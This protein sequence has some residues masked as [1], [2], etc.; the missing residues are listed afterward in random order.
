MVY[1]NP[2]FK[3][4]IDLSVVIP[5]FNEEG[6]ISH[7]LSELKRLFDKESIQNYELLIINDGSNDGTRAE[8]SSLKQKIPKLKVINLSRNVGHMLSLEIGMRHTIGEFIITMDGDF[9]DLPSDAIRMYVEAKRLT[10]EGRAFQV[11]QGVRTDRQTDSF[12]KRITAASYYKLMSLL[13]GVTLENAADFRLMTR[14][15]VNFILQSG[16][17]PKIFRLLIPFYGLQVVNLAVERGVRIGG[18]TKYPFKK[19]LLLAIDS[20]FTF[21]TLPLR[22]I[23]VLGLLISILFI[24]VLIV[25]LPQ[26]ISGDTVPGWT[27]IMLLLIF[28]CGNTLLC[29]G[30]IGEY[31]SRVYNLIQRRNPVHIEFH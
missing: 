6:V 12:Y 11:I 8:L 18:R 24:F 7:T 14:Q 16:E 29:L 5:V 4:S 30:V 22:V 23:S 15:A 21:T 27:S 13:L 17:S 19:M 1:S 26:Y 25:I 10:S 2:N 28:M 31:L 20:I 3:N 9:Q